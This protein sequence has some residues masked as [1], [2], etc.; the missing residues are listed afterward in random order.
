MTGIRCLATV[1]LEDISIVR[2]VD[3]SYELCDA[4][5][6]PHGYFEPPGESGGGSLQCGPSATIDLSRSAAKRLERDINEDY[7]VLP[8]PGSDGQRGEN[9]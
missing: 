5:G 4:S 6:H 1:R 8:G 7:D 3:G 2:M 9:Q